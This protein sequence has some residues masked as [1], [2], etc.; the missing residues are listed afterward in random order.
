M[1]LIDQLLN[2]AKQESDQVVEQTA[3]R[4]RK[5]N[6]SKAS[7]EMV[8]HLRVDY[9][10]APTPLLQVASITP[11]DASTLEIKPWERKLLTEIEKVLGRANRD[12]FSFHNNGEV[13]RLSLPPLTE[14]RRLQR[15]KE[16]YEAQEK[17]IVGVRNVRKGV[18]NVL[19]KSAKEGVAEDLIEGAKEKLQG[20][21]N[22]S[23][24]R[25]KEMTSAKERSLMAV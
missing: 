14:E 9:Y 23:I 7:P 15:V 12:D 21:A 2:K 6:V 4:F 20:I 24:A 25:I 17:G 22:S 5:I 19:E 10:G 3:V 18:K 16:L 13:L 11:V 1:E 8:E